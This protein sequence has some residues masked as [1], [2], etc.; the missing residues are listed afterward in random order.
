VR[1]DITREAFQDMTRDLLDRTKFTVRQTLEAAG[2]VWKDIDRV[3]LVG[4]STRMPAVVAALRELSGKEPDCSVSPD[5]AVAHGAALHAGLLLSRYHGKPPAFR[6]QN[7]NSHSLG[8]VATD[9]RTNRKRNAIIIPRNT[10]LPVT[11]RRVF[12]T[13]RAGQR[14]IRVEIVEG[15]SPS[16]DDC[17]QIGRCSVSDLPPGLPAKSP[18]EVRFRYE[19]NGRLTVKVRVAGA[20][21][22]LAHE[23]TRE[24]T[25]SRQQLDEWRKFVSGLGPGPLHDA[26]SDGAAAAAGD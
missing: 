5:E 20:R 16:P 6:I 25:L 24:N 18:I 1:M 3:L 26:A 9:T 2:L 14:S 19:E 22:A 12:K 10:R 13:E 7:V 17:S 4:G 23:I 15:E 21:K 8:V 11:A